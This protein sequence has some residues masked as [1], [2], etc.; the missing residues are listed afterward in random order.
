MQSLEIR[1]DVSHLSVRHDSQVSYDINSF[2]PA[3]TSLQWGF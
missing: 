1:V 3:K 2:H